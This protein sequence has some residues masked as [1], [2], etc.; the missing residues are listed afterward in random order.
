MEGIKGSGGL[1]LCSKQTR[2]PSVM[3]WVSL[4][5]P[6]HH[7]PSHQAAQANAALVQDKWGRLRQEGH[8]VR[9]LPNQ[10][11]G[12][13]TESSYRIGRGLGQQRPPLVLLAN[14]V[15][16]ESVR[17][18]V[19]GRGGEGEEESVSGEWERIIWWWRM[20]P[21]YR[22][23]STFSAFYYALIPLVNFIEYFCCQWWWNQ[24]S[25]WLKNETSNNRKITPKIPVR[26]QGIRHFILN[27]HPSRIYSVILERAKSSAFAAMI[28]CNL[29]SNSGSELIILSR[30]CTIYSLSIIDFSSLATGKCFDSM[31]NVYISLHV[32]WLISR[33]LKRS[34]RI[35]NLYDGNSSS[36]FR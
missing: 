20:W 30:K 10:I 27:F 13:T 34:N 18:L 8:P 28:F 3:A 1:V 19:R 4:L 7:K 17:L 6:G 32:T 31:S 25:G 14:R 16:E 33:M 5:N 9:N 11:C 23:F 35:L 36:I 12:T 26:L 2:Q 24:N 29:T 15:P 21:P 22:L